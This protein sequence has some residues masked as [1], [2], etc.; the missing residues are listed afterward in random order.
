MHNKQIVSIIRSHTRFKVFSIINLLGLILGLMC[1]M[2]LITHVSFQF[3]FDKFH[4]NKNL[5]FRVDEIS[6]S[7]NN[8]TIHATPR[9]VAGPAINSSYPEVTDFNRFDVSRTSNLHYKEAKIKLGYV[10]YTDANFFSFFTFP[11]INGDF[12]TPLKNKQSI[13]LTEDKASTIFGE[14]NP[15]GETIEVDGQNYIVTAIAKNHPRNSHIKFDAVLPLSNKLE[16]PTI[17]KDWNGGLSTYTFLQLD[18]NSS[19]ESLEA[20]LPDLLWE[21]V[22]KDDEEDGWFTEYYLE[23]LNDIH[24]R[25]K[26]EWEVFDQKD[27]KNVM[28]LLG[29]ALLIL[30]TACINYSLISGGLLNLRLKELNI[31]KNL[32]AGKHFLLKQLFT[33][34]TTFFSVALILSIVLIYLLRPTIQQLFNYDFDIIKTYFTKTIWQFLLLALGLIVIISLLLNWNLSKKISGVISSIKQIGKQR[35]ASLTLIAG[36]QFLISIALIS[37]LL[38]VYRQLNYAMKKDLGFTKENVIFLVSPSVS[39]KK[40][41]IKQELGK[42]NGVENI[43]ASYGLPGLESTRNGYLPEGEDKWQLF[44]AIF[45]DDKFFETYDIGLSEGRFFLEGENADKGKY[46]INETLA[47]ELGWNKPIGKSLF[48]EGDHEIIGVVKDFHLA[49]IYEEIPPLIISKE[50]SED[51]YALSIKLSSQDIQG[52]IAQLEKTWKKIIPNEGFSFS[53]YDETYQRIYDDIKK[54]GNL[55]LIFTLIAISIS[56]LGLFGVTLLLVNSYR[57]EIGVRKVNGAKINDILVMLNKNFVMWV[58]IAF[59]LASPIAWFAMT[60]WLEEFAYKINIS[61]WIFALAGLIT[62]AIALITVSLQSWRAASRNPVEA[63]RYE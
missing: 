24:L 46:L 19:K 13:V 33:E 43:S 61:W 3:S 16:D 22:N 48:R 7:P 38:I 20:K 54:L 59:A 58:I 44:N 18:K 12:E 56:L 37:S 42:I 5:I 30:I 25:S 21:H 32:G 14:T 41:V 39:K 50:F 6:K 52:T 45:V 47:K 53:F 4:K 27:I 2:I 26:V 28:S 23:S 63:L 9:V 57:K 51:F 29:I 49:S 55:L 31:K 34:T 15:I 11:I 17:F 1:V 35:K 60:K 36:F 62:L 10:L 8:T 40:D